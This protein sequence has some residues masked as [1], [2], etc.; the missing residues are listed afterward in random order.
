MYTHFQTQ[1]CLAG[2][3]VTDSDTDPIDSDTASNKPPCLDT[4]A[5]GQPEQLM[6]TLDTNSRIQ[7][8][9]PAKKTPAKTTPAR[10]SPSQAG[11][12]GQKQQPW[13]GMRYSSPLV[14]QTIPAK[15]SPANYLCSN[16]QAPLHQLRMMISTRHSTP[17]MHETHTASNSSSIFQTFQNA[18]SSA[19]PQTFQN[20]ASSAPPQTFQN[21][22]SSASPQMFQNAAS[23]V[24]LQAFQNVTMPR[25]SI[26]GLLS[27]QTVPN[28]QTLNIQTFHNAP[29]LNHPFSVNR[30]QA[31][32]AM[33]PLCNQALTAMGPLCNTYNNA[34]SLHNGVLPYPALWPHDLRGM[35]VGK[36]E[37][38]LLMF[39][40]S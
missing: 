16:P 11:V 28:A 21:A 15:A 4:Q 6:S 14:L 8:K 30:A 23:L 9:V 31:L 39:R 35:L 2:F 29:T 40:N 18:A 1:I 33:G 37:P 7:P 34:R 27:F 25:Q 36:Q 24:P 10:S 32:T 5:S 19:S 20:A 26:L 12:S 13:M 22:A 17:P 3:V 38:L